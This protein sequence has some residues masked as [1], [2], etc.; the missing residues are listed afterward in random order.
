MKHDLMLYAVGALKNIDQLPSHLTF[1]D[2]RELRDHLLEEQ[3]ATSTQAKLR[4]RNLLF[5]D[6]LWECGGRV[7]DILALTPA[8][9]DFRRKQVRLWVQKSRK[10]ITVTLGDELL[11]SVSEFM[12]QHNVA[13]SERL[14]PFT[15]VNAWL[16]LKRL[17]HATGVVDL[18]PHKF[19]H[20]MAIH[21]LNENVP[22]PVIQARLGH[23]N[24]W[25][26]MK[27]YLK[28]TPEV[29]R[30]AIEHVTWR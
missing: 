20:G 17:E 13:K 27:M 19:R 28:V 10:W 9:F 18:H 22:I 15:R 3:P 25:I 21:L 26:T 1:A 2:Y 24:P 4:D 29:Q 6:L 30:T 14:F 12:R 16:L 7:S 23:A 11:L 5:I 8:E